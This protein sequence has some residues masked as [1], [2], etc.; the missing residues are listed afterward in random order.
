MIAPL[1]ASGFKINQNARLCGAGGHAI[2]VIRHP[3]PQTG[4]VGNLY[5]F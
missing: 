3:T 1:A 4:E 2:E 5:F